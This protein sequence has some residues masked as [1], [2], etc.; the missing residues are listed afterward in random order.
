MP[1][2]RQSCRNQAATYK[3]MSDD[4]VHKARTT[5]GQRVLR[6]L[7]ALADPR[8]LAHAFKVVNYY[9]YTHVTPLRK[10]TR[11]Q[12]VAISPTASFANAQNIVIGNRVTIGANVSLWAGPGSAR[13]VLEDD[14][15]IAPN[16]MIT[17]TN[18]RFNDGSPVTKQAMKEA[19]IVIGR[20]VWIGY[21]A[22]ILPGTRIGAGAI[23]GANALVRGEIPANAI[24]ASPAATVIGW[25]RLP[26]DP[27]APA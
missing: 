18:Y 15:L 24:L 2:S 6:F 13:I 4:K 25:R 20:D 22:V 27:P 21:G 7:G 9:N 14:V 3:V 5:R 11:G 12:G 26:D 19:E 16:V 10:L 17:C 8:A 1:R 23:I